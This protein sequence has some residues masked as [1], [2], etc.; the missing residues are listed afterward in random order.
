MIRK[1]NGQDPSNF[2]SHLFYSTPVPHYSKI[3]CSSVTLPSNI[4]LL[5]THCNYLIFC[6]LL[7]DNYN[8]NVNNNQNIIPLKTKLIYIPNNLSIK[9]TVSSL[10][11]YIHKNITDKSLLRSIITQTSHVHSIHHLQIYLNVIDFLRFS[12]LHFYHTEILPLHN[13]ITNSSS[14][15]NLSSAQRSVTRIT[16][17]IFNETPWFDSYLSSDFSLSDY[18]NIHYD[19]TT[20]SFNFK[21]NNKHSTNFVNFT[22]FPFET[23]YTTNN[24]N[25]NKLFMW[26]GLHHSFTSWTCSPVNKIVYMP[27]SSNIHER[28]RFLKIY[29]DIIDRPIVFGADDIHHK[30]LL[31]IIPINTSTLLYSN[32]KKL[33]V[34]LSSTSTLTQCHCFIRTTFDEPVQ[35]VISSN[36]D[37]IISLDFI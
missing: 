25:Y 10:I 1:E 20:N 16:N 3:A 12:N 4:A 23:D 9:N 15:F 22:L 8:D 34:P 31:N 2:H 17:Y 11:Q 5:N 26:L 13:L 33:F 35:F 6:K 18:V 29:L 19:I 27:R 28:F 14:S 37:I 36:T 30:Q 24:V 32:L 21:Y 7:P